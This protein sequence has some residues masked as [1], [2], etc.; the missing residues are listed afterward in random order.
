MISFVETVYR[1]SES[2]GFVEVCAELIRPQDDILENVIGPLV[3]VDTS[4]IF[5]PDNATLAS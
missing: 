3:T 1:A 4:S 5:I 2:D